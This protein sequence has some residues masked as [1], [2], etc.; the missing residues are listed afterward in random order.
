MAVTAKWKPADQASARGQ[1][2]CSKKISAFRA[3]LFQRLSDDAHICDARLLH[4][5]HD[6]GERAKGH[7]LIGADEDEL[8]ARIAH[9]LPY[10][11]RDLVDINS[12]VAQENSLIFVDRDYDPLFRDFF[13]G[14]G[15]GNADLYAGLQN[16]SGHH[17]DDEQNQHHVDQRRDVDIGK[18]GLRAA[19]RGSEGHYRLTSA[20]ACGCIL[21][22]AF[23]TSSEKS[24]LRA[25]N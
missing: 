16:G 21:S 20:A 19:V 13:D 5:V 17:K 8:I 4:R 24:S 9:P 10:A 18:C 11:G 23:R 22:M 6:G 2:S 12:V 7:V 15:L 14:A 3:I 1:L 25:A